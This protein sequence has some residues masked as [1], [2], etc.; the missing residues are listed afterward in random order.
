MALSDPVSRRS[1]ALFS[2]AEIAVLGALAVW[3]LAPVILM[4]VHALAAHARL[5]GADGP[6]GADQLQYLSWA[7]DGGS[8]GLA[9]N[10]FDLSPSA[11]VFAQPLFTLSGL[12]WRLGLP[13]QLAYLLWKPVAVV[14]LFLG[15]RAWSGRFFPTQPAARMA[16]SILTLFLFTPITAL[17]AWAT[18]GSAGTRSNLLQV[19]G[20]LFPAGELWGYLPS[21]LAVALMPLA[22]LATERA[23]VRG[24]LSSSS[25]RRSV[26][27]A[28]LG[29]MLVSWLHPWQGV[30]LLLILAGLAVWGGRR[31]WP[32]LGIPALATLLPLVYYLLLSRL[33]SAWKLAAHNEL[34]PRLPAGVLLAG[35]GPLILVAALGY[36]RPAADPGERALLLWIPA[37][38]LTYLIVDSFSSHALESLSIPI[39]VLAVRGWERLRLPPAANVLAVAAVT[40]PGMAYD[41][42]AF[43]NVANSPIQEYYLSPSESRALDWVAN[44]APPGGVLAPTLFANAVPSQTGRSVWVGHQ[45]WSRDYPARSRAAEALFDGRLSSLQAR[46]LVL[47]SGAR[48]LIGDCAHSLDLEPPLRPILAATHRFGCATVYVVKPGLRPGG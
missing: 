5:T 19:A 48:V 3:G 29:G 30:T 21:A 11:H 26:S 43:R 4:I 40:L 27:V 8:H 24:R 44:S 39:A 20:E 17:A 37:G 31:D 2:R 33:D 14:A 34:V 42:R 23:L 18:I 10:L 38:L 28:A 25:D 9:S 12:L 36:R 6:I 47:D 7:R 13:L 41:A 45:F 15:A 1:G 35:L 22:L 46:I 16:A 32:L